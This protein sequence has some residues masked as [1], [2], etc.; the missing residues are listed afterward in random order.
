MHELLH[1]LGVYHEHTRPDRD[2]HVS[3]DWSNVAD[4]WQNTYKIGTLRDHN[5]YDVPYDYGS[6]MHYGPFSAAK[7]FTRPV[8]TAIEA[9]GQQQMGN[10]KGINFHD[11]HLVN[12]MYGCSSK[13]CAYLW[14]VCVNQNE[15]CASPKP[16]VPRESFVRLSTSEATIIDLEV[17]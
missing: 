5:T 11:I 1:T 16:L 9:E 4:G 14:I 2:K 15:W 12:H 8:M 7:D 10:R 17:V 6:V 13:Y 3:I